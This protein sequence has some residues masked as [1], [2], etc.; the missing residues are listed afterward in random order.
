MFYKKQY[1]FIIVFF[2]KHGLIKKFVMLMVETFKNYYCLLFFFL[3]GSRHNTKLAL[4][5]LLM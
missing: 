5:K 1:K 3:V 2:I 4:I